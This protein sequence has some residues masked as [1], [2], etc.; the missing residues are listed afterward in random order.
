MNEAEGVNEAGAD[1][2]LRVREIALREAVKRASEVNGASVI[3]IAVA[4]ER[5][6]RRGTSR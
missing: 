4:Y 3:E 6:L 1:Y 2:D 5:Y